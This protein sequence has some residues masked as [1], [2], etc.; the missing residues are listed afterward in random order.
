MNEFPSCAPPARRQDFKRLRKL[1]RLI[2]RRMCT[3][4]GR[5]LNSKSYLGVA[6]TSYPVC[7]W[8]TGREN[9]KSSFNFQ[10]CED[11]GTSHPTASPDGYDSAR[12]FWSL[13]REAVTATLLQG[14]TKAF[15]TR[16]GRMSRVFNL[17]CPGPSLLR[18]RLFAMET[19]YGPSHRTAPSLTGSA[20]IAVSESGVAPLGFQFVRNERLQ[21]VQGALVSL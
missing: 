4:R 21:S 3:S 12:D 11:D 16:C 2:R 14:C 15:Y 7:G 19:N 6:K 18:V 10:P 8:G 9:Y 13:N 1:R 17:L 5:D 20:G